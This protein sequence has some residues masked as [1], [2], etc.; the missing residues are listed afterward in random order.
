MP[1]PA[2]CGGVGTG[3]A[4]PP[5]PPPATNGCGEGEDGGGICLSKPPRC[6]SPPLPPST[7][8]GSGSALEE[9]WGSGAGGSWVPGSCCWLGMWSASAAPGPQNLRTPALPVNKLNLATQQHQRGAQGAPGQG[10]T[11]PNG[12]SETEKQIA[13]SVLLANPSTSAVFSVKKKFWVCLLYS[14]FLL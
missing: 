12:T 3:A 7:R 5:Q 1:A 2:F 6:S 9:T 13:L 10:V 8:F 14:D 4:G 11:G